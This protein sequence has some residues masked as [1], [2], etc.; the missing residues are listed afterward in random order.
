MNLN[1]ALHEAEEEVIVTANE[2]ARLEAEVLLMH[3]LQVD[4]VRLY[5]ELG[6][7][8]SPIQAEKY[9]KLVQRRLLHEP[10]SY[11]VGHREFYGFEF[12]VDRR[13]LIPRPETELVVQTSVQFLKEYFINYGQPFAIADIGTGSGAI[14]ITLALSLPWFTVYAID[15]STEALEVTQQNCQRHGV[16][17]RIHLMQGDMLEPLPRPVSL[18]VANLPYISDSDFAALSPEINLYEPMV[19]LL[20]GKDGLDHI[21]RL[22]VQAQGKLLHGGA[23]ILEVGEGQSHQVETLARSQFP[24]AWIDIITDFAGIE[25]VVKIIPDIP[26]TITPR[27]YVR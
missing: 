20:G 2:D 24:H 14:A 12:S 4:R 9:R 22:L 17:Y 21:R 5:T 7:E 8:M 23:I 1:A 18:I 27:N 3:V 25:R 26:G 6:E 11:I 16:E 19:A 15:I 13:V 10:L